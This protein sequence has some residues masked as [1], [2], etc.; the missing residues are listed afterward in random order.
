MKTAARSDESPRDPGGTTACTGYISFDSYYLQIP[1]APTL[2]LRLTS[3][4]L[5]L[6]SSPGFVIYNCSPFIDAKSKSGS[7]SA[8]T[9]SAY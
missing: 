1:V 3:T 8:Y 7:S 5:L 9:E 6:L 4:P 2:T